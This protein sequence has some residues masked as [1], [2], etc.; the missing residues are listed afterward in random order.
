M[1]LNE[2]RFTI[3]MKEL[4]LI[5]HGEAEHQV[6]GMTGGWTDTKLTELGKKQALKTGQKLKLM[7]KNKNFQM[8]SSDLIRA[9]E[10][11]ESIG[12]I[13]DS[14]ILFNS[15]L[16]EINCGLANNKTIKEAALLIKEIVGFQ[17]EIRWDITKPDGTPR[18]MLDVARIKNLGWEPTIALEEGIRQT[19]KWCLKESV[20]K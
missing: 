12:K 6:R 7:L 17:G 3:T 2:K 15:D 16:R 11:A 4:F 20:F 14:S 13:L 1:L 9:S 10:S 18:K 8:Y 19:Y 5:R